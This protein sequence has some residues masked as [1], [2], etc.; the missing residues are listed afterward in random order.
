MRYGRKCAL[1]N[2][3]SLVTRPFPPPSR[4]FIV[5]KY[6]SVPFM[7][8]S[9][10]TQHLRRK[11]QTIWCAAASCSCIDRRLLAEGDFHFVEV[12]LRCFR[13]GPMASA[14]SEASTHI[15]H[16]A[17]G[18]ELSQ[19]S[20]ERC[21]LAFADRLFAQC[22]GRD[23]DAIDDPV[24]LTQYIQTHSLYLAES[25]AHGEPPKNLCVIESPPRPPRSTAG[26][27]HGCGHQFSDA[28]TSR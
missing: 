2:Q 17:M 26:C 14:I 11:R 21:V 22:L 5:G 28:N 13:R 3:L 10:T 4:R 24:M 8:D 20:T 18:G 27:G 9:P 16:Q 19:C 15:N 25:S 6:L 23:R 7:A 12:S 1:H